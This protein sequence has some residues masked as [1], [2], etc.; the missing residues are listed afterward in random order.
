[1]HTV[2]ENLF[3]EGFAKGFA[4]GF[5][6]GF[7]RGLAKGQARYVLRLLARRGIPVDAKARR[8][9]RSCQDTRRLDQW[10]DR[11]WTAS[12]VAE[13]LGEASA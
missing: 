13:V 9:I 5:A 11:A 7:A 10:F 12:S 8:R 6:K 4:E 1:M 3:A 2:G